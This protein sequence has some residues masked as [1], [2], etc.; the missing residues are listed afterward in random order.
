MNTQLNHIFDHSACVTKRQLRDYIKGTISTEESH[1][2]EHHINTCSFCSE[3]FDGVSGNKY[4]AVAVE[5]LNSTFLKEHFS[6]INPQVH[7]NSIAPAA[8][9]QPLHRPI[10]RPK[11]NSVFKPSTILAGLL[12]AFGVLWYLE[13]IKDAKKLASTT[14]PAELKAPTTQKQETIARSANIQEVK[15]PEESVGQVVSPST[16]EV[17]VSTTPADVPVQKTDVAGQ[18]AVPAHKTEKATTTVTTTEMSKV[19]GKDITALASTTTSS[20]P[21]KKVEPAVAETPK[22]DIN[23]RA[24]VATKTN[25]ESTDG[26]SADDLYE[27]GKYSAALNAYRKQM[28]NSSGRDKEFAS[29]QAARCY[30][31][32]GQKQSAI[33]LL[34]DLVETGSGAPRRQA[35][36]LLA[37][38]AVTE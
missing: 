22:L 1:A 11:A 35:K 21:S 38:L 31:G 6:F 25:D 17:T 29:L 7:L 2:L 13:H 33:K 23:R 18:V 14:A 19:I 8:T 5:G 9:A 36:R 26:M 27:S 10:R 28:G 20:I 3:A 34:Q 32:M 4:A 30:I 16:S 12:L 37:D 15:S 24:E